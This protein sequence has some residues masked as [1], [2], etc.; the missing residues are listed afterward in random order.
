MPTS[1][2]IQCLIVA[3]TLAGGQLLF[4]RAALDINAGFAERGLAVLASPWLISALVLYAAAT[5]LW[6]WI[7]MR[8]ELSRAYP[9]VLLAAVLVPLGSRLF[10][11][12]M[13][14]VRY[15][16]GFTVII[17]GLAIMNWR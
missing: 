9:F 4:K 6:V 11:G 2:L 17:A 14:G 8:V 5:G 13:L 1:G 12:E 10:F 15:L 7:L 16:I 3:A